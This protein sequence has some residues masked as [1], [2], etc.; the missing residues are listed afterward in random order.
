VKSCP[1]CG[2]TAADDDL[3]CEADGARLEAAPAAAVTAAKEGGACAA[4]GA[5]NADDGDGYCR[6][7]GY[8]LL[9]ARSTLPG[10][11]PARVGEYTVTRGHGDGDMVVKDAAGKSRL[12]VF[13]PPEDVAREAEALRA[14]QGL[15][16]PQVLSVGHEPPFGDYLVVDADVDGGTPIEKSGLAFDAALS[17]VDSLMSTAEG[18]EKARWSWDPRASD[19]HVTPA[20]TPVIVRLRGARPLAASAAFNAKRVTEALGAALVPTPLARGTP[21]LLRLFSPHTNFSTR[22]T[23]SIAGVRA[24]LARARELQAMRFEADAAAVADPGL[25]RNHNEDATAIASGE[26]FG[27]PYRVLVVCDGVSSSTRADEA[28]SMA[29]KVACDTLSHFARSG[30]ILREGSSSALVAAIRAAHV[31]V[32]TSQIEYGAGAPPGTTIVAALVFRRNLTVGWVGDSRAYWVSEHGAELCTTDHSWVNEAIARGEVTPEAA[33]DSPL[34]HALTRCLG[35]L[36]ESSKIAEIEPGVRTKA[37]PGP[38]SL[39]LCT[40][41]LWN[42]FP[43]APAIASLVHAAGKGADPSVVARFLICQALAQG[44][45]DNV[46]VAVLNVR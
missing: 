27:E 13:G 2:A 34:A 10:A 37:L 15:G 3:F 44:G 17:L 11:T 24:E 5:K 16:F 29:A 7:C 12:L 6:E 45:G 21:A 19:L 20:G 26:I 1:K 30:D 23:E 33:M 41:G 46:S 28:S 18:L 9:R 42:Y 22:A 40:D 31:A 35:P 8:R 14:A 38:G 4:C 25:R 39:V 36:E 43:S 32:C